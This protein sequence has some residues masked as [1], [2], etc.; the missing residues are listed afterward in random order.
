MSTEIRVYSHAHRH[1]IETL[2]NTPIYLQVDCCHLEPPPPKICLGHTGLDYEVAASF[3]SFPA[4]VATYRRAL[5]DIRRILPR[6]EGQGKILGIDVFC[7]AWYHRS[8]AMA[9]RLTKGCKRFERN[10]VRVK[11]VKH[12]EMPRAMAILRHLAEERERKGESERQR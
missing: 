10:G 12:F 4:N 7:G 2:T 6:V 11:E 9:E 1:R 8:V 3:W 5:E